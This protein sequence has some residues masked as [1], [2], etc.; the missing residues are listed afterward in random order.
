MDFL[1]SREA[2]IVSR[3]E[4]MS[5]EETGFPLGIVSERRWAFPIGEDAEGKE[6]VDMVGE[7][8]AWLPFACT[9]GRL[10]LR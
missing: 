8:T 1:A 2:R 6:L 9:W 4:V 10:S 5:T 7:K 3:A